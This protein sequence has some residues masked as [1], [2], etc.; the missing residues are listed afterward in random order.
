MTDQS[1]G[2]PGTQQDVMMTNDDRKRIGDHVANTV[3]VRR[4]RQNESVRDRPLRDQ[5]QPRR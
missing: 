2:E 4:R 3:V 1:P 5:S